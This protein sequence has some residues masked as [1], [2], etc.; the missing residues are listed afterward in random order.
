MPEARYDLG[1]VDAVRAE[2]LGFPGERTFRLLMEGP[3]GE[4]CLWLEKE[5]LF[6]LAMAVRQMLIMVASEGKGGEVPQPVT[7]IWQS[8]S[9][10][11]EFKVGKLSLAHE[12]DSGLFIIEAHDVEEDQEEDARLEFWVS[13]SQLESLAEEALRVCA[14]GRPRCDLCGLPMDPEFHICPGP[15]VDSDL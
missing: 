6:E 8:D 7:G 13:G 15:Y 9:M 3:H 14:A 2:A 12:P 1:H 10:A 4:A 5:Q 11:V